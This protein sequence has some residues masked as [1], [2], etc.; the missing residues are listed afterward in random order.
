MIPTYFPM[1]YLAPPF[2]RSLAACFA[3]TAVYQPSTLHVPPPVQ[4]GADEGNLSIRIPVVGEA[5]RLEAVLRGYRRW[6]EIHSG[7][8]KA[9]LKFGGVDVPFYDEF[10]VNRIRTDLRRTLAGDSPDEGPDPTFSARVFLCMAQ[11]FDRQ[12]WEVESDLT[13]YQSMEKELM[14]HLR[15]GE[16]DE[17]IPG[18]SVASERLLRDPG[19]HMTGDR[20]RAWARLVLSDPEPPS[21]WVTA[22]PAVV[23]EM[24][25]RFPEMK[26]V[27]RIESI[28][29]PSPEGA[30]PLGDHESIQEYLTSLMSTFAT[31]DPPRMSR[32]PS[33]NEKVSLVVYRAGISP[34]RMLSRLIQ[35]NAVVIE[36]ESVTKAVLIG[37]VE[38]A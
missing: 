7:A 19:V 29:V 15:G 24:R 35:P 8:E 12:D 13:S 5:E 32:A 21:A 3:Q 30:K 34:R 36:P 20:L 9:F 33:E 26:E 27:G 2:I 22:S 1:T 17:E 4:A 11:E 18:F 16:A 25:D 31:P 37:L 10:S 14:H 28:F 38:M 6:A 23:D